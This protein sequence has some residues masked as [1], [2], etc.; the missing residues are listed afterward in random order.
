MGA[1]FGAIASLIGQW[2]NQ[3]EQ[4]SQQ[5]KLSAIQTKNANL[6]TDHNQQMAMKMWEDT[7]YEAQRKQLEKAG[8]NTGLMYKGAGEG[9]RAS[10]TP[11]NVSGAMASSHQYDFNQIPQLAL[12]AEMQKAQI[13]NIK[14]DTNLKNEAAGKPTAET[15]NLQA[16]TAKKGEET[17]NAKLQGELM[18]IE[19]NIKNST[20]ED[21]IKQ[22]AAASDRAVGEAISSRA[23]GEIDEAT[24]NDK[25][26]QIKQ[27]TTEQQL[28]MAAQKV[29][30]NLSQ[31]AI[32]KVA[33]EINLMKQ[34]NMRE[35]DKMSQTEREIKIK[36]ILAANSTLQAE[37]N[38]S[39][40]AQLKQWTSIIG[41]IMATK[42]KS[43]SSYTEKGDGYTET[44]WNQ[45]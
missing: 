10:V 26:A 7:N 14:A 34:N 35:W 17:R 19:R 33:T 21:V 44:H 38:T 4:V 11:G 24:Y 30:I 13:D 8:L 6:Q 31:Q 16:E 29:N 23:K 1:A 9:G 5:D 2:I 18:E 15:A 27:D 36:S 28:R 43:G 45:H 3:K 32:Q 25:I 41:D 37:F 42:G 40:A 12:Q 39:T 20:T 22:A